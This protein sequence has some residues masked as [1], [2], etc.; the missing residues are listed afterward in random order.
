VELDGN[1]DAQVMMDQEL[2]L[3]KKE[4]KK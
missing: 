2:Q 3:G 4:R 1:G